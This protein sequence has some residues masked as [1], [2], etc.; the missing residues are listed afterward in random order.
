MFHPMVIK[1]FEANSNN[2]LPSVPE[3]QLE[4]P[5]YPEYFAKLTKEEYNE[6]ID[7]PFSSRKQAKPRNMDSKND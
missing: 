5:H 1:L 4:N 3:K 2:F 7:Y 6:G